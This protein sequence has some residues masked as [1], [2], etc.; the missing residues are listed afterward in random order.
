MGRTKIQYLMHA[1]DGRLLNKIH[2]LMPQFELA[3]ATSNLNS[4]K[5]I[6]LP[7]YFV[8]TINSYSIKYIV[9]SLDQIDP[10]RDAGIATSVLE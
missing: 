1:V 4:A 6:S 10:I 8:Y 2:C 9:S 7:Y 5:N 3:K